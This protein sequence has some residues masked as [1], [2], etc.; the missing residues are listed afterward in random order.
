METQLKFQP[1]AR[2]DA[3]EWSTVGKKITDAASI[4]AIRNLLNAHGGPVLL[5]HRYLR[6]ARSPD[7]FV[8]HDFDDLIEYLNA[9]ARA[10]DNIYVWNLEAF[11]RGAQ[12]LAYGKCPDGD[13]AVPRKGAY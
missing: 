1:G 5:E 4:S 8:F 3:D 13:G 12:P 7:H 2:V 10:G 9:N 6:G 11:L